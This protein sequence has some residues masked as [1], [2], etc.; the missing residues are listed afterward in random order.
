VVVD[1]HRFMRE[2]ISAMLARQ[3]GLFKVVAEEAD[4]AAAIQA[5]KDFTPDLLI[6]DINLPDTSG[7]EAVPHIRKHAPRTRILLC[8]AFATDDRVLEALRCGADGF[9]EKTNTWEDFI[10]AVQRV[11]RGE[12][13]FRSQGNPTPPSAAGHSSGNGIVAPRVRLSPR[14]KQILTLIAH[15]DSSKEIA[16]KLHIGVGTVETHRTNMM[17]KL[18]VRNVAGLVSYAFRSRLVRV[19]GH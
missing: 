1:D 8:T 2:V 12:H 13:F 19:H 14:E 9:V 6:L 10:E 16:A 15:G 7:I 11:S 4:A 18:N 5:C 3:Q 17:A